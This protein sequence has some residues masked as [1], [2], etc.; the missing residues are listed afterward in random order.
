[1]IQFNDVISSMHD[2]PLQTGAEYHTGYPETKN[3]LHHE[4][5]DNVV[6]KQVRHKLACTSI[7]DS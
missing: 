1:M 6:S 2:L 5:T 3:E 4:K 7:E